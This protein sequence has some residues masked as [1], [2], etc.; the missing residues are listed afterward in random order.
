VGLEGL[1]VVDFRRRPGDGLVGERYDEGVEVLG[2]AQGTLAEALGQVGMTGHDR[3]P[4]HLPVGD[5]AVA[6]VADLVPMRP[7]G[8]GRRQHLVQSLVVQVGAVHQLPGVIEEA[9]GERP[10]PTF[11]LVLGRV[12]D[13]GGHSQRLSTSRS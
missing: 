3:G 9:G 5:G 13:G 8:E 1:D 6:G 4:R 10:V 11:E 7:L 2:P 12:L